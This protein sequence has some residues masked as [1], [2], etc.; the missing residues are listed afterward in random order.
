MIVVSYGIMKSGSTLAFEMA[1]AVLELNGFPQSRLSDDLVTAGHRGN[2]VGSWSDERLTDLIAATSGNRVVVK[3][4]ADPAALSTEKMHAAVDA[5]D[6]LL[7]LVYRDPR[8]TIASMFEHRVRVDR[9]PT[10]VTTVRTI[11]DGIAK[12]S[13]QIGHLRRWGAYPAL[14]L[15]YEEFAFDPIV[16]PRAIADHLGLPADPARVWEMVD[17]RFTQKNVARSRRYITDLWPAEN[18][19]IERAFPCFL[20]IT[21]GTPVP[22]FFESG[23]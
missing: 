10:T 14:H 1:K 8:D 18:A 5:G 7:H 15:C 11:G 9:E 16:G 4:H 20:D 3:T 19:R 2:F 6:L 23:R 17:A 13:N 22:G 21:Q 12:L